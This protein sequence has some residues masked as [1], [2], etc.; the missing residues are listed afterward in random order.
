MINYAL[1]H[2]INPDIRQQQ[3]EKCVAY[4]TSLSWK[5]TK[6]KLFSKYFTVIKTLKGDSKSKQRSAGKKAE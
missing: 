4:L 1:R 2:P 5:M 6:N 3:K